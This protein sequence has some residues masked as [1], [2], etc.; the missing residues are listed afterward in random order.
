MNRLTV[1]HPPSY[2]LAATE[3]A[4]CAGRA[5]YRIALYSHDTMGIGH[6]RRNLL[7]AQ[8]LA[9]GQVPVIVLL[10]AGAR[11]VNA[12]AIP[13]GV[14]YLS[15]PALH[16][17]GNGHYQARHLDISLRELASLRSQSIAAALNAFNPDVLIVDK[18]PRGAVNELDAALASLA[19]KGRTRC[20]LGLRDVLDDAVTVRREWEETASDETL[21][22]YY[23]SIWVYGDPV[24]CDPR[25]EYAFPPDIAAKV[26]FT[27]YL[28]PRKRKR[29][30]DGPG[31]INSLGELMAGPERLA[32]CMVGGGQDGFQLVNSFA[33]AVL[34]AGMIG[35]L[36]TG[37]FM[38]QEQQQQLRHFAARNPQLRVLSFVTDADLLLER[39]SRIITMG[40]YNSVCEALAF[41]K[42]TLIVPRVK[43]RFEQLIRAERLRDLGLLDVLHPADL[44]PQALS[45]WLALDLP[46]RRPAREQLDLNGLTNLS[47]L[48]ENVLMTPRTPAHSPR[49]EMRLHNV[50]C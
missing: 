39:A 19:E 33:R 1:P 28:D 34:P 6:M 21:R 8:E 18:V 36:V 23:D 49:N 46:A 24:I 13:P 16:K 10:I 30:T 4:S 7:I 40:G 42:A 17:T 48:L 44:T 22:A 14:D 27:G 11:E 37:P 2:W 47:T 29:M 12:F 26:R 31:G 32:L 38:P 25:T 45:D 5:K 50:T 41:D 35:V 9:R 15:L 43:P 20:V 3:T